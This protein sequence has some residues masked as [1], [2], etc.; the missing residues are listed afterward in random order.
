MRSPYR[1]CAAYALIVC[2]IV[3]IGLGLSSCRRYYQDVRTGPPVE[4]ADGDV[5]PYVAFKTFFLSACGGAVLIVSG[6]YL[7]KAGQ[8]SRNSAAEKGNSVL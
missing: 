3:L 6:L 8:H 1:R 4:D 7:R 5:R 2:G